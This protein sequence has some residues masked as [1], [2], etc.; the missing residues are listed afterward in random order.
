M[1]GAGERERERETWIS[2]QTLSPT[3]FR[4]CVLILHTPLRE[5]VSES[6]PPSLKATPNMPEVA[7]LI[8]HFQ[9]RAKILHMGNTRPLAIYIETMT[10]PTHK[11]L[12]PPILSHSL[13]L[14]VQ[15][16][17]W[18][19]SYRHTHL[20]FWRILSSPPSLSFM[21]VNLLRSNLF[22]SSR[23]GDKPTSPPLCQ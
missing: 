19:I 20:P 3:N 17:T 12:L 5:R 15:Q 9:K 22:P 2:G 14:L 13:S 8:C 4:R 23:T 7:I 10:L 18:I 1:R 21:T 16:Y 11:P 6:L